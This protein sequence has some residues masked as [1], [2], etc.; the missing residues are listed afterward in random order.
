[1]DFI[2]LTRC[3]MGRALLKI[4]NHTWPYK[5]TDKIIS[6]IIELI[7]PTLTIGTDTEALKIRLKVEKQPPLKIR[8][9]RWKFLG[10]L[11]MDGF[12]KAEEDE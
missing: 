11:D 3:R 1:M 9:P 12:H 2:K 7:A 4:Q 8:P 5:R 6:K 10:Y